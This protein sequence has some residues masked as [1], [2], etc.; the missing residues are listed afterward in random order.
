[1]QFIDI[2]HIV[3]GYVSVQADGNFLERFLTVCTRRNLDVWQIRYPGS[4]RLTAK[5][6]LDSFRSIRPVC[7]RTRTRLRICRRHGLPFL[8]HRYRK[9]KAAL[10][11]VALTLLFLWYT[12]CHIMGITVLGNNRIATDTVLEH[13]ARSGVSV[14]KTTNGID[15]A[16]IRNQMMRDLEDLAWIG[17]NVSGSRVYVEVVERLEKEPGIAM[18]EP[19]HL[20]AVKDGIIDSMEARNG[21]NMV[22]PG[23]GVREGDVLVSGMMDAG[24]GGV[25]YVHAYGEV[26]AK[27]TYTLTKDF[28]FTYE[29]A[30]PTG[31]KS[32]R[33]T[34]KI[35]DKSIP[36]F[37]G[38]HEPYPQYI[39]EEVQQEYRLP[40]ER[41]PS[42]FVKKEIYQEQITE[43]KKRTAGQALA[44]AEK[45]LEAELSRTIPEGVTVLEKEVEHTLTERDSLQVTMTLHCRENIAK[46]VAIEE[47]SILDRE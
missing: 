32:T 31:K 14:G 1:M 2:I 34:L 35:F 18:D 29:E 4:G 5:M 8:F 46:E 19:C 10:C 45:E 16:V 37:W 30:I 44:T 9:R 3:K 12:S 23:S 24:E 7:R 28:P 22:K 39:K 43:S 17:I 15:A 13:L 47:A 25:R 20:V 42:L 40:V 6:S 27:T 26:L 11:G 21:Q 41:L 36:L 33:Y 38:K